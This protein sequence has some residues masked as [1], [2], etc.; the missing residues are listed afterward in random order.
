MRSSNLL[1]IRAGVGKAQLTFEF[2]P[3]PIITLSLRH[4]T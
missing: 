4:F 1:L 3:T 2:P